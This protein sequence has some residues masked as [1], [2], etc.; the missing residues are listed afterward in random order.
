MP[1]PAELEASAH[2]AQKQA[3]LTLPPTPRQVNFFDETEV[4]LWAD[5]ELVTYKAKK[6]AR[7]THTIDEV[8]ASPEVAKRVKYVGDILQ[9]LVS[10]MS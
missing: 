3:I 8:V 2:D 10:T 4:M 1:S 6:Q 5:K 9:Q 7:V